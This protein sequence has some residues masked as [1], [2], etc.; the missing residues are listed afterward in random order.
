MRLNNLV[1]Y[2]NGKILREVEF[3]DG[4]NLIL[5][6][7]SGVEKTGNSVGKST[8]SR[9]ID[10]IFLSSGEDI[11][12]E[13]E[14][15]KVIPEVF[16]FIE[17]NEIFVALEFV[18]L[19][20]HTYVV[21][22]E[23]VVD[24]ARSRFLI[25]GEET[26]KGKYSDLIASQV[27]G[28]TTD[29]PS[30][31][32]VS[33]KFIRNT[34]EK[35]QNTTRFLNQ[36]SR[37]DVYDQL[38]LFLFGFSG[39]NLL[40]DKT[41]INN[42]LRTKIRHLA[43]Y[44]SPHKETALEKMLVP[45]RDEEIRIQEKIENFDFRDSQESSV[46]ELVQIQALISAYTVEYSGYLARVDYLRRS[47]EKLK[48]NAAKVDGREL[49]SIYADAGVAISVELKRSYQDLVTFHNRVISNKINLIDS[50]VVRYE[51]LLS[52][53][54]ERIEDLHVAESRVFKGIKEPEILRSIGQVYNELSLVKE[55]I[56]ATNALLKKIEE[57]KELIAS[58]EAAKEKI[59]NE[60]AKN[61]D[62]F[63]GNVAVF[64]KWFSSLSRV[65]YSEIYLFDLVFDAEKERC[66][67]EVASVSPNST[68]GK[69]KGELS[70][71]DLAYINFVNEVGLKRPTFIIHDS[72]EDVDVNQIFDIFTV[73]N[74]LNGQYIVAVLNDK[75]SG[76]KFLGL[77]KSSVILELSE[78]DKFF[79]I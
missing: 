13:P 3:K 9:V 5:N 65:F 79:R 77:K 14:F 20:G 40:R 32:V 49:S 33:H 50:D 6:K 60:I 66:V 12:T 61:T 30:V 42:R 16:S 57:A 54:K 21:T 44:R 71:F 73:A 59:V 53:V 41:Q 22:R 62:V 10:Y 34:H 67:F 39:L 28:L 7:S 26:D 69:K 46:R 70:A 47:I 31:R 15:N 72:I 8:L 68:G 2:K 78:T 48:N 63:N 23:L 55:K 1:V 18:G 35:M 56:A 24:A 25:D 43:A 64:N 27:F 52:E 19:N 11:Y 36:N 76:E 37:S 17:D 74:S 51:D 29:K 58:L 45:L 75:I 4:L 38:Y